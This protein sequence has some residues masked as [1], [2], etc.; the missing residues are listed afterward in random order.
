MLELCLVELHLLLLL[1]ECRLLLGMQAAL[2]THQRLPSDTL[3]NLGLQLVAAGRH[4]GWSPL[5]CL[6]RL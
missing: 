6:L 2:G 1:P 4:C 3:R 5:D